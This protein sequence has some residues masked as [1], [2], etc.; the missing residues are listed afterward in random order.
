MAT[1]QTKTDEW[2]NEVEPSTPEHE[3]EL[4]RIRETR[5]TLN[6]ASAGATRKR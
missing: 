2:D 5:E 3:A 4:R 1:K 6:Y